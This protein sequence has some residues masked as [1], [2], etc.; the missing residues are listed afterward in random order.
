MMMH[1]LLQKLMQHY[2]RILLQLFKYAW[3]QD[4]GVTDVKPPIRKQYQFS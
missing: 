4:R 2:Q 3:S 1:V